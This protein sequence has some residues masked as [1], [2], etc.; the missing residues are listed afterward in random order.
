MKESDVANLVPPVSTS[1]SGSDDDPHIIW[2]MASVTSRQI[3][4]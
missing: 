4:P 1:R 2:L 3:K